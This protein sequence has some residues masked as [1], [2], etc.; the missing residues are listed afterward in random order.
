MKRSFKSVMAL[1][2]AVTMTMGALSVT[3]YA[4]EAEAAITET[5]PRTETG[6]F[7]DGASYTYVFS[8]GALVV[9][10]EGSFS[11][12]EFDTLVEKYSPVII[13]FDNKVKFPED[14]KAAN[15]WLCSLLKFSNDYSVLTVKGSDLIEKRSDMLNAL[16]AEAIKQG[17]KVERRSFSE[18]F[19][20][21]DVIGY[22]NTYEDA[23]EQFDFSDALVEKGEKVVTTLV[24]RGIRENIAKKFTAAYL[25]NLMRRIENF[26]AYPDGRE[27]S[28]KSEKYRI[29][30]IERGAKCEQD[31]IDSNGE[32]DITFNNVVSQFLSDNGIVGKENVSIT[33]AYARGERSFTGAVGTQ[34][35][36]PQDLID[37]ERAD[38]EAHY[39]S[40][41][42]TNI[43]MVLEYRGKWMRD[44]LISPFSQNF[45]SETVEEVIE[46]YLTG[47][48]LRMEKGLAKPNGEE[49]D[50]ETSYYYMGLCNSACNFK[51]SIINDDPDVNINATK[52]DYEKN[53][54]I[55]RS[56]YT[57][58][59]DDSKEKYLN[60]KGEYVEFAKLTGNDGI[61]PSGLEYHHCPETKTIFI[62]GDGKFTHDDFCNIEHYFDAKSFIMGKN[63]GYT[64][65]GRAYMGTVADYNELPFNNWIFIRCWESTHDNTK[66][67]T[68]EGSITQKEYE[69]N[70]DYMIANPDDFDLDEFYTDGKIDRE[71]LKA[72]APLYVIGED[73]DPYDILSGGKK[74]VPKD[75]KQTLRGDADVNGEVSLSDV[76]AVAKYNVSSAS[77]PLENDTAYA[78]ADMN[79]DRIIDARDT[80]ALIEVNLGR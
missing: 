74:N 66:F 32:E 80:S 59:T 36:R 34:D 73:E 62:D 72:S 53:L 75:A 2:T 57:R 1:L 52:R 28:E 9:G 56:D 4:D 22:I 10:G 30:S 78:N 19:S 21:Q 40:P 45:D 70:F 64:D 60:T 47:L 25:Y 49:L 13:Y 67:Y 48:K 24:E 63:V 50:D 54:N 79:D 7:K 61:L 29:D 17:K 16:A 76:I 43:D 58:G 3:A 77:Y 69:T 44:Y 15:E 26:Y 68:V 55:L 8:S 5:A 31:I 12:K 27:M 37:A 14:K 42:L 41:D 46:A 71:K 33:R 39:I 38:Y 18:L 35:E 20:A 11:T 6:S 65:D 51:T 23:C